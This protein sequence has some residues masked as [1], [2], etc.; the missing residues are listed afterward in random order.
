MFNENN[1]NKLYEGQQSP[2]LSKAEV[3]FFGL[4]Q[5]GAVKLED[6]PLP[7]AGSEISYVDERDPKVMLPLSQNLELLASLYEQCRRFAAR[8]DAQ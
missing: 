5:G 2:S 6:V 1:P 4:I 8:R 3:L 7:K